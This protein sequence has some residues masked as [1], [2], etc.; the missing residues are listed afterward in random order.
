MCSA[1]ST[2]CVT[3]AGQA[4]AVLCCAI[5]HQYCGTVLYRTLLYCQSIRRLWCLFCCHRAISSTAPPAASCGSCGRHTINLCYTMLC[6]RAKLTCYAD[7]SLARLMTLL[8]SRPAEDQHADAAG[9]FCRHDRGNRATH[10][11]VR[12]KNAGGGSLRAHRRH[13]A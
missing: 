3:L 11:H 9:L 5:P 4:C 2:S 12:P 10:A 13:R 6:G 8:F 7:P 1:I